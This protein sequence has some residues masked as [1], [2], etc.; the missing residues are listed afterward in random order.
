MD[1]TTQE[2][3]FLSG[4]VGLALMFIIIGLFSKTRAGKVIV[5]DS[6]VLVIMLVILTQAPLIAKYIG[7]ISSI[8]ST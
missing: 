8:W 1:Y 7:D 4:F 3:K 6:I 5:Y 2:N